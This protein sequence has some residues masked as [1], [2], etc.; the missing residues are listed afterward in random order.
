MELLTIGA[1]ARLAHLSPKALRIY[2]E[3]ALLPPARVDPETGYRWYSTAQLGTARQVGLLRQVDMPL[4]RIRELLAMAPESAARALEEFWREQERNMAAK[5]AVVDFLVDRF[6]GKSPEMY[7][8]LSR[9]LPART[10]FTSVEQLTADQIG[11]FLGP[12]LA[13]FS[14]P[15]VPHPEGAA[16]RPFLRYHGE[17]GPE[18]EAPVEFC[19]P[20]TEDGAEEV[21]HRFPEMNRTTEPAAREIY[22]RVPKSDMRGTL[23]FES[24]HQWLVDNGAEA[25]WAPRQTFLCDPQT[26]GEADPVYELSV[27][28]G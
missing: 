14:G 13:A 5:R 19:G 12:L 8:V 3:L 16:G 2:D 22:V 11:E 28:V 26:V 17:I 7:E 24:L 21:A 25:D 27:T 10:L 18:S 4:A 1:F 6:D 9:E 23:G 15:D 20:V